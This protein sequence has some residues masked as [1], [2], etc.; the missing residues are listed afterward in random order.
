MSLSLGKHLS[1]EELG[2]PFYLK[3]MLIDGSKLALEP[4]R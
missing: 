1:F 2:E 4:S 3:F